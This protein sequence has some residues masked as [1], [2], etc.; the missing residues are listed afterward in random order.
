[1]RDNTGGPSGADA[2]DS[3]AGASRPLIVATILREDGSTGV[4]TH[5]RQF[6]EYLDRNGAKA[7]LLTPF[8]WAPM[9]TVPVFGFRVALVRGS[10][11]ASVA[12]YRYWHEVFLRNA[13]GKSLAH[14]G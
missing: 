2:E 3:P 12:W 14:D 7:T 4:Q 1:M 13:L 9:L 11:S 5:V 6:R 10:R 8:S